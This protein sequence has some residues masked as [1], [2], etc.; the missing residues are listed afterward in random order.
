MKT[1]G[2]KRRYV[3]NGSYSDDRNTKKEQAFEYLPTHESIKTTHKE[4]N[5]KINY[6]LL[7]RFLRRQ[8]G[9][10]WN[11]VYSELI[12][13]I[14]TKLYDYN[15]M[16]FSFV[17]DKVEIVNGVLYNRRIDK[18]L[19]TSKVNTKFYVCPMTNKLLHTEDKKM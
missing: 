12:S 8:I 4:K 7:I 6:G 10:D 15:Y 2:S 19:R 18:S 14:P 17:A 1:S 13:R 5:G 3:E 11:D 9:K 16:I